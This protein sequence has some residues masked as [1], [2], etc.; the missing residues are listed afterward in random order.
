MDRDPT[1]NVPSVGLTAPQWLIDGA[2][3][4]IWI[5]SFL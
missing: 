1:M 5:F 2:K 3:Y 4:G